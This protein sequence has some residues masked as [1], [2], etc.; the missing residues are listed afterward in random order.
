[1][2]TTRPFNRSR[3]LL[4][5]ALAG[6][7]AAACSDDFV[8]VNSENQNSETYFNTEE[9]YQNALIGAYDMLQSSYLNVM[10]GEIASANTL[11]GGESATDVIGIQ[12]IDDMIHTPTNEQLRS[13]WS[14]MY[15]GVNRANYILEFQD[16]IDFDGKANVIGQAKFLRA[17]YYFEL[18]KWF[19]DV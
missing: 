2:K 10:L 8:Y 6:L 16:K 17:Y 19:G 15:A 3:V 9:D 1:M 12:Q 14:W 13:I 5:T 7:F 18:V 11:A 4:I